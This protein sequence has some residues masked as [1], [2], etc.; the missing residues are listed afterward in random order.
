ML[1]TNN[2]NHQ[3][4]NINPV[5][6]RIISV[7]GQIAEVEIESDSYPQL[8]E[9]LVSPENDQIRLEVYYQSEKVVSCLI[10]YGRSLLYRGM[11]ITGT[12]SELK[13]PLSKDILGRVINLFGDPQDSGGPISNANWTP[14]YSKTPALNTIRSKSELLETG[15]K[16]IDFLT[17]FVKGGKIGFIGGAG[18]GKTILMTELIHNITAAHSGVSIFAGVGERIREGQELYQRLLTSKVMANTVMILGQ[19]NEN[20]AIRFRVAL[21]AAAIAEYFR[22][23]HHQD[24]LFFIDNMFRFVQAGSE[25]STLLGTTP[26]EQAYQATLQ[27]EISSLEDRLVPTENGTITS[28][29]TVYVPSDEL[30]DAGVNAIMSFLDTAV[31]LSRSI[32][33]MGIYPPID[34]YQSSTST[35]SRSLIS[36]DHL[37]VLTLFQQLLDRYN[38]LSHI[39]AIVGESELS[40]DDQTVFNRIKKV[41]NYLTQPFFVT[42]IHTGRKGVFVPI[43]TT[44]SDIR[45]ILSGKLD[46]VPADKLMYIGDLKSL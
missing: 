30:T 10:L 9:I 46:D 17:P 43:N 37:A 19:M 13:T 38:K 25:V 4:I 22:D 14:I 41:I 2:P 20:A 1:S 26:S 45:E 3:H 40:A 5:N 27:T 16:A 28:I 33:Q 44:I 32:A 7:N 12:G 15:I 18:V 39:V 29:Q 23:L 21:A 34:L 31:V 35:V 6:G 42:E 36:S 24:V 11:K 8:L